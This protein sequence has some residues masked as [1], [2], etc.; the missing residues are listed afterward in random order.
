MVENY[1]MGHLRIKYLDLANMAFAQNNFIA[2]NGYIKDFLD[3]VEDDTDASNEIKT[4]FD[5]VIKIKKQSIDEIRKD[6]ENLGYLEKKD[7]ENRGREDTEINAIH[8]MKEICWRVALSTGL[9][10]D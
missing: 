3:T 6:A 5:K 4:E 1:S 8:D 9:F 2:A 7:F 10:N